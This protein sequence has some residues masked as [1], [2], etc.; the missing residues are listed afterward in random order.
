MKLPHKNN[1]RITLIIFLFLFFSVSSTADLPKDLQFKN[2]I[3][4]LNINNKDIN[5][6]ARWYSEQIEMSIIVDPSIK[7][8]TS[9]I[10][11]SKINL[12]DAVLMFEKLLELNNCQISKINNFLLIEKKKIE[13]DSNVIET[14]TNKLPDNLE[15]KIYQLK[16]NNSDNITKIINEI[17]YPTN[18]VDQLIKFIQ[19]LSPQQFNVTR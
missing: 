17:F 3:I 11:P 12:K 8:K 6:I 2:K 16:N 18:D 15:L 5:Y 13:Q 7:I 14:K 4:N 9:L 1:I 19:N 10:A